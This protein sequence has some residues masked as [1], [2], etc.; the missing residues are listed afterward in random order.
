MVTHQF[1]LFSIL[2]WLSSWIYKV[3]QLL[4]T[5]KKYWMLN[6]VF[7]LNL[8]ICA[9]IG[10][11]NHKNK[12]IKTYALMPLKPAWEIYANNYCMFSLLVKW[13]KCLN[14]QFYGDTLSSK[15]ISQV[16]HR[17]GG[18][19]QFSPKL[20]KPN[21]HDCSVMTSLFM[22]ISCVCFSDFFADGIKWIR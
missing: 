17:D 14:L 18:C 12:I 8:H 6:H 16:T 5:Y 1:P 11:V 15:T 22:S 2:I 3:N 19:F 21:M 20:S 13:R 7:C 4:W 9:C 10:Y